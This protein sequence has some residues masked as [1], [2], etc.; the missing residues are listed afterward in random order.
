LNDTY[1]LV[2]NT[3]DGALGIIATPERDGIRLTALGLNE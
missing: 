2:I 1:D 3:L